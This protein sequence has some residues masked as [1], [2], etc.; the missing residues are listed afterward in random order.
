MPGARR[1]D[2]IDAFAP[3][4]ILM[5]TVLFDLGKVLLDWDPRYF[6]RPL[7]EGDE[8]GMENF[9]STAVPP[10]WVLE[11]DK[12][13]PMAQA[14]EERRRAHPEHAQNIALW[15]EGW[16]TMLRGEIAGSVQ[17]LRELKARG[18]RLYALTNFSAET[19]PVTRQRFEFLSLFDDVVVSAEHGLVKPDLRIYRLAVARCE[20]EPERTLFVDDIEANVRAARELG[21]RGLRFTGPEPLRAELKALGLI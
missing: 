12:G 9:L 5:D 19:W 1:Y 7:F 13:K 3:A 16:N 11:M 2:T 8:R 6:Y 18:H 17:L 21:F 10:A 4:I 15:R 20:L 14:I